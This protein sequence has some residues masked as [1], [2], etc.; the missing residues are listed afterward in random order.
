MEQIEQMADQ[1]L[2]MRDVMLSVVERLP[3]QEQEAFG[4]VGFLSAITKGQAV[5]VLSDLVPALARWHELVGGAGDVHNGAVGGAWLAQIADELF[6]GFLVRMCGV[7]SPLELVRLLVR[8]FD[9]ND[10]RVVRQGLQG[11]FPIPLA[12]DGARRSGVRDFVQDTVDNC[13]YRLEVVSNALVTQVLFDGLRATGVR[14]LRKPHAYF[15]SPL[16]RDRLRDGTPVGDTEV[17]IARREVV[18]AGG[19][20]NTPQL[21]M[22]SGVGPADELARCDIQPL[23]G[24]SW[25]GVGKNLQCRY[26]IAVISDMAKDFDVLKT[27]AFAYPEGDGSED[28]E[29]VAW[30][31][32]RGVYTS[33]GAV[34]SIVKRSSQAVHILADPNEA[35]GLPPPDLFL[36]G[37]LGYFKGYFPGYSKLAEEKRNRLTWAILKG[38]T[39]NTS[40]SVTLRSKDPRETPLINFRYFDDGDLDSAASK[41]DMEAIVEGVRLVKRILE[42]SG[43]CVSATIWPDF[44]NEDL[45]KP[46]VAERLR[47]FI[48]AETWGHHASGTC[49]IGRDPI[50]AEQA[51]L[52]SEFRV[53]GIQGLRV[54][55]ASVF[56]KI[57]GFFIVTP[58]YMIAEKAAELI[59]R[60]ARRA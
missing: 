32:R 15:A 3:Q 47:Q 11:I 56:P 51:V 42:R 29:F 24:K 38:H 4:G 16:S 10:W 26:E 60:D 31:S 33:N 59:L 36:F 14:I 55:D 21:L 48:A 25:P 35:V 17:L 1:V 20:F 9:P 45:E 28:P 18:L 23:A 57:P 54:V 13:P 43:D 44:L 46:E 8:Y 50:G 30:K 22:L 19:A 27:G 39:R 52:D 58:I 5:S 6:D 2:V 7:V 40:G 34:F 49:K 37:I 12:T 53:H 41:A